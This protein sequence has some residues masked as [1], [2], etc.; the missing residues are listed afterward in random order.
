LHPSNK[1]LQSPPWIHTASIRALHPTRRL[2]RASRLVIATSIA[3]PISTEKG[4]ALLNLV[5]LPCNNA[6]QLNA[7]HVQDRRRERDDRDRRDRRRSRS[8]AAID[9]YQ[10]DRV[11]R[12]EYYR[13]DDDRRDRRR[14]STDRM[15]APTIDRYVPNQSDPAPVLVNPLPDPMKLEFQVGFTWF[16]EWWRGEERVKE[17]KAYAKQGRRAPLKGE[18]EMR[19]DREAERPKIQAAYDSYKE[20]LQKQQAQAFVRQHKHEDWFRERYVPEVNAPFRERLMNFRKGLFEQWEQDLSSGAFDEF[21]LEGIPKSES[22]GLGGVLEKEEGETSAAAEVLGVGDLVPL[23]G[24]D[25]RDQFA[26]LPT[27]LIKT[28]GPTVTRDK[29]EAFAKEHLGED[30]GGFKHLSLSDPNPLKRCHRMGWIVLNPEPSREE[31]M[32]DSRAEEATE[33]E[34]GENGEAAE[35]PKNLLTTSE[36]GLDKVNGKTIEDSERGNFTVHCALHRP[37]D[38][39]RKKALW[40]L[41]SAP[42]RIQRDLELATRLVRKLDNEMGEEYFG[43]AKIE[44]RVTQLAESGQLQPAVPAKAENNDMDEGE[45][46]EEG[47]IEEDEADDE[48]LLTK[49]KKLDLLVEYLRRVYSFCFFCVFES[50]SVHELQRKCPG[51]HLRRPRASLT[52]S[53]KET[54]RASASGEPFPL[55]KNGKDSKNEDGSKAI[56]GGEDGEMEPES[57]TEER[58]APRPSVRNTQQLQRAYNWVKTFEEKVLQILEPENVNVRKIGGVPVEEGVEEELS[59]VGSLDRCLMF[60]THC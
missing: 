20:N 48:E 52:T 39:P 14:S 18:R 23:R 43:V 34:N 56:D 15:G 3:P 42:E 45:E 37:P 55:R 46:E 54:A 51:G 24:G 12:D 36:R 41:F 29:L 60:S 33:E 7:N 38:A 47:M 17:E 10:P 50:D 59:K 13:R 49:K 40:D 5:S 9:R 28:I 44:E 22:N 30:E 11:P 8:P 58:K 27:L 35:K 31:E 2:C 1:Y 57:P 19:Q 21:T 4:V 32:P 53:A 26:Q 6:S 25:I 16:A